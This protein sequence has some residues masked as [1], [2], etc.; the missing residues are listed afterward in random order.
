MAA[1]ASQNGTAAKDNNNNNSN[2]TIHHHH[3]T[4]AI[5][6]A[7]PAG[8]TLGNL[9]HKHAIPFTIFERR[10]RP[11]SLDELTRQPSGFLDLHEES[12]LAALR[13]C[14]GG[15]LYEQFRAVTGECSQADRV[16]DHEGQLLHASGSGEVE[17]YGQGGRGG[18]FGEDRPEVSRAWLTKI[19]L[20]ALPADTIRWEHKLLSVSE[21][22]NSS[23][24]S[25]NKLVALDFG[26]EHGRHSFPFVVG[27]DGAW[28]RVRNLLTDVKPA[29]AGQQYISATARGLSSRNE[30]QQGQGQDRRSGLADLVGTGSMMALGQRNGVI[31][32]RNTVQDTAVM[33]IVVD[34][35]GQ[36]DWA[37]STGL[38]RMTTA[39]AGKVLVGEDGVFGKWGDALKRLVLAGCEDESVHGITEEGKVGSDK[40]GQKLLDVKPMYTLPVGHRWAHHPR[41]TV[42]G[43]AAHLMGPW[44]GEGVN[45]AMQDALELAE[46]IVGAVRGSEGR[47]ISEE[48]L[49]P[50][51][52]K[53]EL[54]MWERAAEKAGESERNGKLMFGSDHGGRALAAM[55]KSFGP[56]PQ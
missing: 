27:A 15:E 4:I 34:A 48:S 56:P 52:E 16:Y 55:F 26:P 18:E 51:V 49:S 1:D 30:Q 24:S 2:N 43:D 40:T 47:D 45:T 7:G 14:G 12:G 39:E 9:L 8:L 35:P 42:I 19:L 22:E 38:S 32:H 37:E 11:A 23:S 46:A 31:S 50:R 54:G 3:N 6:G 25:N 5:I 33:Y 28:S 17:G 53:F 21:V 41:A 36:E 29:Y 20:E 10:P 44:A 13:A